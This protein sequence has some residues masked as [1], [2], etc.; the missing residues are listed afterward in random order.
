[1]HHSVRGRV[2]LSH[3]GLPGILSLI[4]VGRAD[5]LLEL[6]CYTQYLGIVML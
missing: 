1:M 2:N 5:R 4:L 6:L 3:D